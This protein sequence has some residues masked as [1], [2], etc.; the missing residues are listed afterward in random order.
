MRR[1]R[2]LEFEPVGGLIIPLL[3]VSSHSGLPRSKW[4]PVGDDVQC[5]EA[6]KG[7]NADRGMPRGRGGHRL[8]R[9]LT[10]DQPPLTSG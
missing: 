3:H 8:T 10:G 2:S 9:P 7:P 6:D 4:D 1:D 5:H